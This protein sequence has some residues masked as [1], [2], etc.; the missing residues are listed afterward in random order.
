MP[1]V[2]EQKAR[3]SNLASALLGI[4]VVVWAIAGGA[5]ALRGVHAWLM[6]GDPLYDHPVIDPM[7]SLERARYLAEVSWLGPPVAYWKPPLYDYFLAL[8]HAL[9]GSALWP[10][11]IVQILLDGASC[12]L[13]FALARRLLSRQAGIAVAAGIALWGLDGSASR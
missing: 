12:V 4:P 8:H 10:A 6:V 11:R 3:V 13:G 5:I 7:E 2:A 1:T 9:F